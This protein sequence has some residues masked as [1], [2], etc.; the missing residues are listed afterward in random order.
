VPD[1]RKLIVRPTVNGINWWTEP[2]APEPA[3]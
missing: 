2:I 3:N 1:G